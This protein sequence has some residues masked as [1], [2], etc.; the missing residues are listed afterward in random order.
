VPVL[1]PVVSKVAISRFTRTLGTLVSS[2]VPILQA[3][4]IV[5]ETSGNVIIG[6]AVAPFMKASRKAKPSPRRWK[7]P[8]SFR[9]WSS[10]WWMSANKPARCRKC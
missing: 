8:A 4:T 10:A 1:G 6:N 2:G 9:P 7:P 3:L 5:K